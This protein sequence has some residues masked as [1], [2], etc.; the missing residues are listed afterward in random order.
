MNF[1]IAI[2]YAIASEW[3]L[4][5]SKGIQ[6]NCRFVKQQKYVKTIDFSR[7]W[8]CVAGGKLFLAYDY[9]KPFFIQL[10]NKF[11]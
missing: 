4:T 5:N 2:N 8:Y 3:V 9:M 11:D 7:H 6:V 10:Q 1:E